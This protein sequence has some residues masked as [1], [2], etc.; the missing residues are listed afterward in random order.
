MTALEGKEATFN[1]YKKSSPS[2]GTFRGSDRDILHF[3][4]S[5]FETPTGVL[6]SAII[7]TTDIDCM[8]ISMELDEASDDVN[9]KHHE[10][11]SQDGKSTDA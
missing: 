1:L 3:A 4:V 5:D 7:R 2:S 8:T 6:K 9:H 11:S 10:S